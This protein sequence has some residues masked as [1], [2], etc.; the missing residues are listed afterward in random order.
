MEVPMNSE[1]NRRSQY[2]RKQSTQ[3]SESL[4]MDEVEKN[5]SEMI[6]DPFV[7]QKESYEN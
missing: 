4:L 3:K 5:I 1:P 2:S 7:E 6:T